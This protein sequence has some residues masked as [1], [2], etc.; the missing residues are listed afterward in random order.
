MFRPAIMFTALLIGVLVSLAIVVI[1]I[2]IGH[3]RYSDEDEEDV[4]CSDFELQRWRHCSPARFHESTLFVS[5][6][7]WFGGRNALLVH[8]LNESQSEVASSPEGRRPFKDHT[9]FAMFITQYDP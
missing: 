2:L 3:S 1:V 4:V 9:A 8:G 5:V 6:G 7:S